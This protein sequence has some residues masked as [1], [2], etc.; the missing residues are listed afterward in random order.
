MI[1]V[2]GLKHAKIF[3]CSFNENKSGLSL[4]LCR[5]VSQRLLMGS[6]MTR[7]HRHTRSAQLHLKGRLRWQRWWWTDRWSFT[8]SCRR[9]VWTADTTESAVSSPSSVVTPSTA[10][11]SPHTSGV[12]EYYWCGFVC[13][14]KMDTTSTDLLDSATLG[15]FGN[16]IIH[17]CFW[18]V[19]SWYNNTVIFSSSHLLSSIDSVYF[20]LQ[21][22]K[23]CVHFS[24]VFMW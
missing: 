12:C 10:G 13:V 6:I 16:K 5:S 8:C 2:N 19:F 15:P 14:C 17:F 1:T 18:F 9:R 23:T 7:E 21:L 20:S 24:P 22:H 4:F 3:E 11:S